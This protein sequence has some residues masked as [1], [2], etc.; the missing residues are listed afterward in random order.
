MFKSIL[1]KRLTVIILALVLGVCLYNMPIVP[2]SK[3]ELALKEISGDEQRLAQAVAMVQGEN[4][5]QGI[6]ILREMLQENPEN[7]DVLWH[8]GHFSIQ[9]GQYEKAVERFK[10]II[11]LDVEHYADAYF[12]LGRTYATLNDTAN[13]IESFEIYQTLITDTIVKNGVDR[14][15]NELKKH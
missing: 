9:S 11:A 12:Y 15:I 7:V 13:A 8:L 14:F 5:M 10:Q 1:F 6:T 4:P 2:E 3:A